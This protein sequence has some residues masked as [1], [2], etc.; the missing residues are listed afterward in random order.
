MP[1]SEKQKRIFRAAA[2][3]VFNNEHFSDL[4]AQGLQP[5]PGSTFDRF[6]GTTNSFAGRDSR[7]ME[8]RIA[9][10]VRVKTG[11]WS[12]AGAFVVLV[13]TSRPRAVAAAYGFSSTTA[14]APFLPCN[15]D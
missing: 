11:R 14:A 7:D 12:A 5:L 2:Y 6:N 4:F 9:F 1:W 15:P 13:Q 10:R 8:F 3:N